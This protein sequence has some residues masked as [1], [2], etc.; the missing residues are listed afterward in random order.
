MLIST[1]VSESLVPGSATI[2]HVTYHVTMSVLPLEMSTGRR[3][4][5]AISKA[6]V[7]TVVSNI[8]NC[9]PWADDVTSPTARTP[10]TNHMGQGTHRFAL[11]PESLLAEWGAAISDPSPSAA[12]K[13]RRKHCTS[14]C[15]HNSKCN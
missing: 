1:R 11:S 15:Q 8:F 13:Q 9:R 3:Q 5:L 7:G 14:N 6:N 10:G 2:V 4:S 12:Q